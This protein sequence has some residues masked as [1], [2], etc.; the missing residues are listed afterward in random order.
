[1]GI[2]SKPFPSRETTHVSLSHP[3]LRFLEPTKPSDHFS[4]VPSRSS[5]T[6]SG[7]AESRNLSA[8]R[9]DFASL[10]NLGA[11]SST[12]TSQSNSPI[13]QAFN[14][15]AKDLQSSTLSGAQQDVKTI[16]QD[17]E[18]QSAPGQTQ[19]PQSH[20]HG[21]GS[22]EISQLLDRLGTALQAGALSTAQHA[23]TS[24]TQQSQPSLQSS[25]VQTESTS[26]SGS[27]SVA[28]AAVTGRKPSL[29]SV[30]SVPG[31]L[32]ASPTRA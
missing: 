21:G 8:V 28:S 6:W 32:V 27:N 17:F 18:N 29:G 12:T 9:S 22:S 16:Q 4:E 15:L 2:K 19:A 10:K 25:G 26:V 24:P 11:Q 1:M 20:H 23:N 5:S 3:Q 31:L 7:P 13:A 14:R 30:P